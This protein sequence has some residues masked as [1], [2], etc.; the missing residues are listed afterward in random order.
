MGY[1]ESLHIPPRLICLFFP[2]RLLLATCPGMKHNND[3]KGLDIGHLGNLKSKHEATSV[4]TK[5]GLRP[6]WQP[7]VLACNHISGDKGLGLGHLGN[8]Q[9]GMKPQQQSL[10]L[11]LECSGVVA[12]PPK[13]NKMGAPND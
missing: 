1:W 12:N 11:M 7:Y 3:E 2:S 10:R 5:V 6:P 4:A 8:F 13:I 9:L